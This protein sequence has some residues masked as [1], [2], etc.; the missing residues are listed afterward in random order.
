[1]VEPT[2]EQVDDARDHVDPAGADPDEVSTEPRRP[3][4]VDPV[5][6]QSEQSFPASDPPSW[7]GVSI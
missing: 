3:D 5:D 1:M 4:A 6:E 2:S 7:P